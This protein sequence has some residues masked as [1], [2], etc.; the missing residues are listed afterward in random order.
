MED[1]TG[2]ERSKRTNP[3]LT[4][5]PFQ[6]DQRSF[7]EVLGYLGNLLEQVHYYDM[8]NQ[9]NGTWDELI[10]TDPTMFM[11][12]IIHH[13]FKIQDK[14]VLRKIQEEGSDHE[15]LQLARKIL[16]WYSTIK[17][18]RDRLIALGEPQLAEKI[19]Q[20]IVGILRY[21]QKDLNAF[22]EILRSRQMST[23]EA[24]SD[25]SLF[26]VPPPQSLMQ[27]GT[28]D[29]AK[30]VH[31]FEKIVQ[32]I[33][34]FTIKYLEQQLYSRND[35]LPNNAMYLAFALLFKQAQNQLNE[36]SAKHLD[37]YFRNVLQLKNQEGIASKVVVSFDLIPTAGGSLIPLG[38]LL[39]AGKLFGSET[40]VL[41]STT[42][43]LL[44]NPIR[45]EELHTLHVLKSPF[46]QDGTSQSLVSALNRKDLIVKGKDQSARDDWYVF[47]ANKA[48]Q[49]NSQID[50]NS[51]ANIGFICASSVLLLS[52]GERNVSMDIRLNA[53]SANALLWPLLDEIAAS[54]NLRFETA[55]SEVFRE[56]FHLF[57]STKKGWILCPNHKISVDRTNQMLSLHLILERKDP[58]WECIESLQNELKEPALKV[59][60]NPYSPTYLYSF[61][62]GLEIESIDISVEVKEMQD[63]AI[64]TQAG[65]MGNDKPFEPFGAIPQIG[66]YVMIGKSEWYKKQLNALE[67]SVNWENLPEA[68]GGFDSYYGHYSE[69]MTN[70]SFKVRL[71]ALSN[72]YWLPQTDAPEENLFATKTAVTPEGYPRVQLTDSTVLSFDFKREGVAQ[73]HQLNDP[74]KHTVN[75]QAG[76]I[77]L[78]LSQPKQAFGHDLYAH[79]YTAVAT[80]NARKKKNHPYPNKPFSPK[81]AS[82]MANYRASDK[83]IFD[84]RQ[85][86]H[87]SNQASHHQFYHISPFD[88]RKVIDNKEI[89]RS[90][91]LPGYSQEG[92]LILGLSGLKDETTVSMFFHFLQ[93]STGVTIHPKDLKWEY[94]DDGF[95][96][97]LGASHILK[98][99]T[100]GFIKSGIVELVVPS[101][102]KQA[103]AIQ[104]LRISTTRNTAHYPRI[105]GIYI[106]AVEAVC[107]SEDASI[108][109]QQIPANC[110]QKS[111]SKLPDI[112]KIHQPSRSF[113]GKLAGTSDTFYT[114]VSERL[115]HKSRA[116]SLWDYERLILDRFDEV[117]VVKCTNLNE[118]FKATPGLVKVVAMSAKWTNSQ[119]HYFNDNALGEMLAYLNQNS[120][121]FAQIEVINPIAEYVLVNCILEFYPEYNGGYYINQV[122]QELIRFLSPITNLEYTQGGIGE[123][124]VPTM[125]QSCIEQLPFVKSILKL[126]IEHLCRR[127][128]AS[129]SLGVYQGGESIQPTTPWSILVPA[130]K[131]RIINALT[132]EDTEIDISV[133]IGN[134]EVGLDLILESEDSISHANS[135]SSSLEKERKEPTS[136][137]TLLIFK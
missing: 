92:Y 71:N 87:S 84:P 119:R 136:D 41:F 121:T 99:Q 98:D 118:R 77:K 34:S 82:I 61:M 7:W 111:Q 26:T 22:K 4:D 12:S 120:S 79:D 105:E 93:S 110:I 21:H 85:K 81:A 129:F 53:T 54:R 86:L 127:K 113:G 124:I 115:R 20:V 5:S 59:V 23:A 96:K 8:S 117:R 57:Y 76:F 13:S 31:A 73:D 33:N 80:Y 64:Y 30:I 6:L 88:T 108:I 89:I 74:L 28:L 47:G 107:T 123:P 102:K 72:G 95:W 137:D 51:L 106:N 100:N 83:L 109:G 132:S 101:S 19:Q 49:Q 11:V 60:L 103:E 66:S 42:Q 114:R 97:P 128:E 39:S 135:T 3:H 68:Y 14:H 24:K 70:D 44:A 56:G 69:S 32:R 40:D 10:K 38:T 29:F 116:V 104:W 17:N 1:R 126:N 125:A 91:L 18:W 52:E 27:D 46:I 2:T 50:S 63:L 78:T 90:T 133:G 25:P 130:K 55:F 94:L 16:G 15:K 62:N 134:M 67:I 75:A 45:L 122:N 35:H 58:A 37:F 112:K 48:T 131:H 36:L 9:K 43:P 65:Q